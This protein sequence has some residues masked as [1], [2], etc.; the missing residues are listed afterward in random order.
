[1]PASEFCKRV[2][3][4]DTEKVKQSYESVYHLHGYEHIF[5]DFFL[6]SIRLKINFRRS[7]PRF[8]AFWR[9]F[10]NWNVHRNDIYW[11]SVKY[12]THLMQISAAYMVVMIQWKIS[13]QSVVLLPAA[14]AEWVH[15]L[16]KTVCCRSMSQCYIVCGKKCI[17]C[18]TRA[19]KGSYGSET[20]IKA[21][22]E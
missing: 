14:S 19:K 1:M 7:M 21:E 20:A 13:V 16:C 4:T 8:F 12:S 10:K 3:K 5:Q 17:E 6:P 11:K 15:Q 9:S 2:A 22:V 18:A